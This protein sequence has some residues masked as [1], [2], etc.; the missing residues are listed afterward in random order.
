MLL[1]LDLH[2]DLRIGVSICTFVLVNQVQVYAADTRLVL[3][4]AYRP[5]QP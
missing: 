2:L 5:C 4:L 3:G 1:T